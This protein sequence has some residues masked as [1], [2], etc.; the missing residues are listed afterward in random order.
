MLCDLV[1]VV[2]DLGY[3]DDVGS[4]CDAGVER[5]PPGI[6]PH[7]LHDDHPMVS[8]RRGVKSIDRV[9]CEAH[10]RVESERA[11]RLGDVVVDRLWD[12][13]DWNSAFAELVGDRQRSVPAND[14]QRVQLE[15]VER[16]DA[17]S[18]IVDDPACRGWKC[19]RVSSVGRAEDSAAQPQNSGNVL[20]GQ[21]TP[22][23]GVDQS[24][25][26]VFDP[27]RLGPVIGSGFHDCSDR[28]V[29]A[30]GVASSCQDANAHARHGQQSPDQ[31]RTCPTLSRLRQ[32]S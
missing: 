10:C 4:S 29:E 5:D 23:C 11:R 2:R 22:V 14:D 21:L 8:L 16:F 32:L 20:R 7:D 9:G 28:G 6:A 31:R 19:E 15:A 17:T 25:E 26:S 13:D 3:E 1:Q 27:D 30:R 12:A 18:R 24:S